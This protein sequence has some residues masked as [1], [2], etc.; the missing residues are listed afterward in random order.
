MAVI[1]KENYDV[2]KIK[3]RNGKD[4]KLDELQ[5]IVNGSIEIIDIP[6]RNMIMVIN[7]NGKYEC[8]PNPIATEYAVKNHAIRLFDYICGNVLLCESSMVL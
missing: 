4:F 8:N 3:P 7:E 1:L 5:K 6:S 2:F